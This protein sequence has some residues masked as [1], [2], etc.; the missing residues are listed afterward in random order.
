MTV[1]GSGLRRL[2]TNTWE[3]DKHPSWSGDGR[4]IVFYSNRDS[5]R[6]QIWIM[7]ADGGSLRNISNNG[8]NDWDPVWIK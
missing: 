4:Q 6:R 5:G 7:D 8:Y 3:W 1:D 2:T